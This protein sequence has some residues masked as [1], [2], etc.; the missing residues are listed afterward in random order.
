MFPDIGREQIQQLVERNTFESAID[1]LLNRKGLHKDMSSILKSHAAKVI[2]EDDTQL[3]MN[4]SCIVNKAKVFYKRCIHQPGLLKKKLFVMF[5][6]EEGIDA[7][8]LSIDFFCA[9]LKSLQQDLFEGQRNRLVPKSHWGCE[10]EFE[11]AGAA[12]AHSL[13]L[14]GPG[15][16]LLHPAVYAYMSISEINLENIADQPCAEDIPWNAATDDVKCFIGKV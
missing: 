14:G 16:P 15:F 4:R 8:A 6:G 10:G 13:L 7:G 2:G 3:K 1:I 9:Y 11:M 5:N 12:I